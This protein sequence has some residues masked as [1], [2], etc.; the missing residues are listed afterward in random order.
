MFKQPSNQRGH[1][2]ESYMNAAFEQPR[3]SCGF[4][5]RSQARTLIAAACCM[6]GP[7]LAAVGYGQGYSFSTP[8]HS[9]FSP[10]SPGWLQ[11]AMGCGGDSIPGSVDLG[12]LTG[13]VNLDL[14]AQTIRQTGFISSPSPTS[15]SVLTA[16]YSVEGQPVPFS[17][18]VTQSLREGGVS[19]DTGT[20]PMTWDSESQLYSFSGQFVSSLVPVDGWY[21]LT[22]GGETLTGFFSYNLAPAG[23]LP[24][25]TYSQLAIGAGQSV[26][27][28]PGNPYYPQQYAGPSGPV[29]DVTAANGVHVVCLPGSI[30]D[31]WDW[32]NW[33]ADPVALVPEP[34]AAALV[35]LGIAIWMVARRRK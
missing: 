2:E 15:S 3:P 23:T 34:S 26:T 8:V 32:L 1:E 30:S 5:L 18:T 31:N 13:T 9:F 17:L 19:F 14:N 28:I 27:L 29:I 25:L 35:G 4:G 21:S 20:E 7:G 33:A 24:P 12:T 16:S 22:T 10:G 11:L 6:F